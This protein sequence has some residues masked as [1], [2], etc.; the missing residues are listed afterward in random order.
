M[1]GVEQWPHNFNKCGLMVLLW[2]LKCSVV[3]ELG[4]S[5]TLVTSGLSFTP[6]MLCLLIGQVC[7]S[8]V[9][10]SLWVPGLVHWSGVDLGAC[11]HDLHTNGGCDQNH[12][13]RWAPYWGKGLFWNEWTCPFVSC[14]RS[15]LLL[16]ACLHLCIWRMLLSKTTCIALY[17]TV[18]LFRSMCIPWVRTHD[19]GV[20]SAML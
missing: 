7:T 1:L 18:H 13:I 20:A 9:Q 19:I 3:E 17:Y 11:V 6:G 5:G 8:E 12:S 16:Y 14:L 2:L 4:L 10:Q 15:T